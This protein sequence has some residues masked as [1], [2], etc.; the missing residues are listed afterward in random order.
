MN[1]L[2][3]QKYGSYFRT[4]MGDSDAELEFI[5][6]VN[7]VNN[8]LS[9]LDFMRLLNIFRQRYTSLEESNT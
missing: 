9:K 1:M 5:Y 8:D 7:P 3:I 2:N 6:G 4:A